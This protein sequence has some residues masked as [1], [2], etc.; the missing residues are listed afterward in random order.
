MVAAQSAQNVHAKLQIR[1]SG[2]PAGRSRSQHSQF[3]ALFVIES[4]V[5]RAEFRFE[6]NGYYV[7]H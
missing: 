5:L 6:N 1:A 7:I 4:R 2:L 3:G